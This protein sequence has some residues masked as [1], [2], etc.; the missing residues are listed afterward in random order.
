MSQTESQIPETEKTETAPQSTLIRFAKDPLLHFI[1]A[2]AGIYLL[3]GWFGQS[4]SDDAIENQNTIVITE[5]EL[6]WLADSWQKR[7]NRPPT[8]EEMLGLVRAQL[9]E[10]VLYREAISMGL[11]QDDTIIRRRLAQKLEFLA[12]DLIQPLPA[13]DESLWAFFEKNLDRYRLPDLITFTHVFLDPD[14]RDEHTLEDA[15]KLKAQLIANATVPGEN[16]ELGDLFMLQNYYPERSE[17]DI[18]K[19]F[20]REFARSILELDSEQWHGPVLSGYGTHLVYVHVRQQFPTPTF[21]QFADRVRADLESE[22]REK[23]NQQYIDSLLAR[24]KIVVEGDDSEKFQTISTET[25]E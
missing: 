1:L 6:D 8:N 17:A 5:G 15:E 19:L 22:Q 25:S 7:W 13:S 18:S 16:S 12:Q 2:G 3:F 24:Y 10:T 9:R 11:D 23:L 4:E 14:K 20:G 21:E